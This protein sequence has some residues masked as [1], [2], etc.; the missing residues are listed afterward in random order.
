MNT[1]KPYISLLRPSQWIKNLFVFAAIFFGGKGSDM[2]LMWNVIYT[3]LGFCLFSS[4]IYV[5]N[6]I[7]DHHEDRQHPQK[8]K[9][10]IASGKVSVKAAY[11]LLTLLSLLAIAIGLF[12]KAGSI[13]FIYGVLQLGYVFF[14]KK[15]ALV[16]ITC[17][18][19]G[20]V[21]RVVSGGICTDIVVSEWLL[22][23]TFLL[24]LFIALGKRYDDA[25]LAEK[26]GEQIRSSM[27]GYNIAFLQ[28]AMVLMSGI[29]VAAYLMYITSAE[30]K[31]QFNNQYLVISV[32]FVVLGILR[33]LQSAMVF[34]QTVSPTNLVY[35]DRLLQA[36]IFLW[37]LFFVWSIYLN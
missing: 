26:T 11:T 2:T 14:L 35:K 16:D 27:S 23:L 20:F 29:I 5:L 10:P 31:K 7:L 17:I 15:I 4:V 9:R 24:A 1:L 21:L 34:N 6:D 33:Y 30:I 37:I 36:C 12:L 18:A 13:L 32:L 19:S 8:S 25:K 22:L 28:N 3:F